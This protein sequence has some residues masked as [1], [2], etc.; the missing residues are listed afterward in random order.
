MKDPERL[1]MEDEEIADDIMP[2]DVHE[3]AGGKHYIERQKEER[4]VYPQG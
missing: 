3:F 1:G 2:D 4:Y